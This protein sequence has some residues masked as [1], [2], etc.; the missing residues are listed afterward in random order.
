MKNFK[1]NGGLFGFIM[2]I[3]AALGAAAQ[4]MTMQSI[5]KKQKEQDERIAKLEG[6]NVGESQ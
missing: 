2:I 4:E 6:K 1:F 3:G 5:E